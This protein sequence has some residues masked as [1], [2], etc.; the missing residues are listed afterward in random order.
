[1]TRH[2]KASCATVAYIAAITSANMLTSRYGMVPAGF[3][4]VVTA[5]TYS[6]GLA[7]LARDVVQDLGGRL[8]VLAAIAAGGLISWATADPQIALASVVAFTAAETIDMAVY[9]PLRRKGWAR[10]VAASNLVGGLADTVIFL[11]IAGFPVTALTV[12]GQMVGKFL[13]A[14]LVPVLLAVGVRRAV[15]SDP[16]FAEST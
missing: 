4:L 1:V 2:G 12:T 8:L 5:G 10:A 13:W 3:G 15:H 9:T 16:Q 11:A 14:T 7:L 6:A